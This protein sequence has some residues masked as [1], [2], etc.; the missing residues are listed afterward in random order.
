V[1]DVAAVLAQ[2]DAEYTEETRALLVERQAQFLAANGRCWQGLMTHT[3]VPADGNEV[4]PDVGD[5][6]PPDE[7]L[8]W[9]A[10][11][12]GTPRVQAYECHKY[13]GPQGVGYLIVRHVEINGEHWHTVEDLG[14]E[15]GSSPWA[16]VRP[17]GSDARGR[18]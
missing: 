13:D 1:A 4:R 3:V 18:R 14:P 5:G 11:L 17:L 8:P 10:V 12:G 15:G 2:C 6:K 7:S 9:P 16:V